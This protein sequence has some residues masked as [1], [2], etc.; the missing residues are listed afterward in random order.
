MAGKTLKLIEYGEINNF[1]TVKKLISRDTVSVEAMLVDGNIMEFYNSNLLSIR[2]IVWTEDEWESVKD[3]PNLDIEKAFK[4][5]EKDF[6]N[7][8]FSSL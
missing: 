1:C 6:V 8:G 4:V 7:I 3:N 5:L 2:N